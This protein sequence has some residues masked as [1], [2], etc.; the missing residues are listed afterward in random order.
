METYHGLGIDNGVCI[1]QARVVLP[2]TY[3]KEDGESAATQSLQ[4]RWAAFEA[5]RARAAE[6]LDALARGSRQSLGSEQAEIFEV[7]SMMLQDADF[8]AAVWREMETGGDVEAA[9]RRAA[10]QMAAQFEGMSDPYLRERGADVIDVSNY[11]IEQLR[12]GAESLL[13]PDA[14]PCILCAYD[15]SPAQTARLDRGRVLGFVTAHGSPTSHTAILARSMGI[16]A[17]VGVGEAAIAA[18]QDGMPVA[19]DAAK[20]I[21]YLAPDEPTVAVLE[22]KRQALDRQKHG[23]ERYRGRPTLTADG[24]RMH[25]YANAALPE[26]IDGVLTADAE[27]IGL[28]RSEFLYLGREEPPDEDAQYEI[29]KD[30]LARMQG[31]R[32]IV[33]TLDIGADKQVACLPGQRREENP[34]LGCRAVRHSLLYPALF[35][36]QARA[37][38]RAS[39]HGKLSVMFPLIT[40]E[41]E[42][43]GI[44]SLWERARGEVQS[45]TA[46]ELGIMIET[47]AA[48]LISDRLARM[49]D[50]FSIGTNDLTQYTLAMDRQNEALQPF[51]R[52]HHPAILSLIRMTVKNAHAAGI[53]VGICGELGADE[54]LTEEF[55]RM[56][57]DELS[58]A[59]SQILALREK[60]AGIR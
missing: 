48:A 15:L 20:G 39:Q 16:P 13:S 2:K 26:D 54:E 21:C 51:Y 34:A 41:Q 29:Y 56:G 47:P 46:V 24:R 14:Q 10:A 3:Q 18:M 27:G 43:R 1:G 44:L 55:V 59:P 30:I 23:R 45:A 37:L 38:L 25:L 8:R 36:T 60:I 58:V 52:P 9:I 7:Q 57:I 11:V 50:F 6:A 42:L 53:W 12:G 31:R 35:L 33:R 28:F 22:Q 32:V 49:V 4:G 19:L 5:A 17:V 40:G